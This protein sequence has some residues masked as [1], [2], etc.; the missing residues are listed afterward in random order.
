VLTSQFVRTRNS[1]TLPV[2]YVYSSFKRCDAL[3]VTSDQDTVGLV[4]LVPLAVNSADVWERAQRLL[5]LAGTEPDE[6]TP[7]PGWPRRADRA[8][9]T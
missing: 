1:A 3:I 4:R 7:D 8:P 5:A 9:S 6:D 2:V